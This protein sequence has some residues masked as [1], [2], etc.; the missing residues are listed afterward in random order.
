MKLVAT[1]LSMLTLVYLTFTFVVDQQASHTT[2]QKSKS[3]VLVL[4]AY[5]SDTPLVVETIWQQ[6]KADR[7]KAKQPGTRKID[8][9]L[10][11]RDVLTI[12]ES[13]YALYGIFNVHKQGVI[14]QGKKEIDGHASKAFI[15][16][17]PLVKKGKSADV[18][19]LKVMQG[20]DVSEGVTLVTVT[21]NS[22]S[23]KHDD[24]L[25]EFKL[26]E[27]KK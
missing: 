26:F 10:K 4:P 6:L 23:F 12:G 19:M 11:N 8:E 15:L 9:A 7:L 17:K 21:S 3:P 18:V 20:E 27:A 1:F 16:I 22:I 5:T 2:D 25:T 13:K 24:E 14:E